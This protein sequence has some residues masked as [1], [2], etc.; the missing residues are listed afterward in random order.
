MRAIP[1]GAGG[2]RGA[3]ESV[4][5]ARAEL[6]AGH[7]VCIFA[8]GAISRTGNMLPFRRGVE[9]ILAGL[10]VPVI[11]VHLD[12]VWGSIFS[13]KGGNVFWKW[14][15]R[16]FYPVTVTFGTPMPA[17]TKVSEIRLRLMELGAE[18][19]ALR[20]TRDDLVHIRFMYQAKQV[21]N[22]LCM[23]DSTGRSLSL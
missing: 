23:A 16:F 9:H 18:A 11:P 8:E 2:A 10:D 20:R 7:V 4:R 13:F 17:K 3:V 1:T 14:P 15:T 12:Q 22:R 5:K 21:W 6:Q 19:V